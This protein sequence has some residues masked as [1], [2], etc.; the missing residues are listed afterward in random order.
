MKLKEVLDQEKALLKQD[1]N[2]NKIAY[3]KKIEDFKR[4]LLENDKNLEVFFL[5]TEIEEKTKEIAKFKDLLNQE[6]QE[7]TKQELASK[8]L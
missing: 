7:K 6:I 3:E 2:N 4:I 5:R 1:N 8:I